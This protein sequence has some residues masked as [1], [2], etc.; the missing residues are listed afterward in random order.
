MYIYIIVGLFLGC[1]KEKKISGIENQNIEIKRDPAEHGFVIG[2]IRIAIV[3][4]ND[5]I[6]L[7]QRY[8]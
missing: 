3:K 7:Y 2:D 8:E 6:V 5:T 4:P 1:Q